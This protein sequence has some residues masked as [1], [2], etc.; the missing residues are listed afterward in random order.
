[1]DDFFIL[2]IMN[3]KKSP[4]SLKKKGVQELV[5]QFS[6]RKLGYTLPTPN[7]SFS[8]L[9]L[10]ENMRTKSSFLALKCDIGDGGLNEYTGCNNKM[11]YK[12]K[13]GGN[14]P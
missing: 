10:L 14:V 5:P 1:M 3:K 4:C 11:K 9:L 2:Y 8:F 6:K 12:I 7:A 13:S